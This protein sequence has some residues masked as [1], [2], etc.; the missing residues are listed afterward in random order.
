MFRNDRV[1]AIVSATVA[2]FESHLPNAVTPSSKL[3][4]VTQW[5]QKSCFKIVH[6]CTSDKYFK[7][8]KYIYIILNRH[9]GPLVPNHWLATH[10]PCSE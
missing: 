1:S 9:A 8:D 3:G 4:A 5:Q 7:Y 10:G 2:E 6:L